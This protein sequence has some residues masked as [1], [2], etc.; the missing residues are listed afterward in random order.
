MDLY[1]LE[2][3]FGNVEGHCYINGGRD[4]AYSDG[5]ADGGAEG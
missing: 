1:D 5:E 2:I 3:E 4:T